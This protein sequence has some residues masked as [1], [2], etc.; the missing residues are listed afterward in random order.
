MNKVLLIKNILSG[1]YK[2]VHVKKLYLRCK[3]NSKCL[4]LVIDIWKSNIVYTV[5]IHLLNIFVYHLSTL[6][7]AAPVQF[8]YVIINVL[9]VY[10]MFLIMYLINT[11]WAFELSYYLVDDNISRKQ[12]ELKTK[13]SNIIYMLIYTNFIQ[14]V[15]FVLFSIPGLSW[16]IN[17]VGYPLFYGYYFTNIGLSIKDYTIYEK[18]HWCDTHLEYI[19]GYGIFISFIF[20][21]FSPTFATTI[22]ILF[23]PIILSNTVPPGRLR[24]Q[25]IS[26]NAGIFS[27]IYKI[28]N[29]LIV[30]YGKPLV[31]E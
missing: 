20:A 12:E 29:R 21:W 3:S 31:K 6:F 23:L 16:I 30:Y 13:V 22:Y 2:S 1:L 24:N 25:E 10:P 27:M 4:N 9:W 15:L 8:Y 5:L 14:I 19:Y 11:L 26:F 17:F 18:I 7:N 28:V